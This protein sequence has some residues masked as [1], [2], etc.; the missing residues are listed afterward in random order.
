M[1]KNLAAFLLILAYSICLVASAQQQTQAHNQ[2]HSQIVRPAGMQMP[3]DSFNQPSQPNNVPNRQLPAV[4]QGQHPQ[5]GRSTTR[6]SL[7]NSQALP[8]AGAGLPPTKLGPHVR[9]GDLNGLNARPQG[10]GSQRAMIGQRSGG[11]SHQ[12]YH[13]EPSLGSRRQ[14]QPSAPQAAQGVESKPPQSTPAPS[15]AASS[16]LAR[17]KPAHQARSKPGTAVYEPAPGGKIT[18]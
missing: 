13:H 18:F 2:D 14:Q 11:G 8:Q 6:G 9:A 10:R 16:K 15:K 17:S 5:A 4:Q 7:L 3:G 12:Q 1:L